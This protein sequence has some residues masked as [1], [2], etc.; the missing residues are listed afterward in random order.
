MLFPISSPRANQ[1][2]GRRPH[3]ELAAG[4]EFQQHKPDDD[5]CHSQQRL[6]ILPPRLSVNMICP[7]PLVKFFE[8]VQSSR[9]RLGVRWLAGNGADTAFA[10]RW[11]IGRKAVCALTPHP[12]HSKTSRSCGR[13]LASAAGRGVHAASLSEFAR[14]LKTVEALIFRMLK[15]RERRAPPQTPKHVRNSARSWSAVGEG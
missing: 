5:A 12:P 7:K 13:V 1:S 8:D 10:R 14:R 6:G 3:D 4:R 15:R 9:Q 2:A 11:C